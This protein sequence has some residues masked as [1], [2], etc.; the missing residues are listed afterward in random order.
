MGKTIIDINGMVYG[1]DE[2]TI[3]TNDGTYRLY[4]SRG[5]CESVEIDDVSG[6]PSDLIGA[7]II[8][9]YVGT[10]QDEV[11]YRAVAGDNPDSFTWSFYRLVSPH[12]VVVMRWLG[13]SNGYY[14]EEVAFTCVAGD[15]V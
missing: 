5:C 9:A 14:S 7:E 6:D 11:L 15:G 10:N 8:S 4:H 12:G 2:V 3:A 13:E 1:S